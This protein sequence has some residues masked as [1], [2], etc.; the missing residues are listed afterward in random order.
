MSAREIQKNLEWFGAGLRYIGRVADAPTVWQRLNP[1]QQAQRMNQFREVLLLRHSDDWPDGP[2]PEI[3]NRIE[4]ESR[5]SS[6]YDSRH[7]YATPP[8]ELHHWHQQV[9]VVVDADTPLHR[10]QLL[11]WDV[12]NP[13][14]LDTRSPR[15]VPAAVA[16]TLLKRNYDLLIVLNLSL[17]H[18]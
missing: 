10:G 3:F 9:H 7:E 1:E 13:T 11:T 6:I 12:D 15:A 5:R 17:I 8:T 4:K 2:W 14:D 16:N 18:I